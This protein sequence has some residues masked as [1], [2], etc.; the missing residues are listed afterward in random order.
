MTR[1]IHCQIC[2]QPLGTLRDARVHRDIAYTH[3]ACLQQHQARSEPPDWLPPILRIALSLL[4][5]SRP[6]PAR[7]TPH[8]HTG[9]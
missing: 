5:W 4:G 9:A 7:I 2:D 3:T 1:P 8:T 6:K